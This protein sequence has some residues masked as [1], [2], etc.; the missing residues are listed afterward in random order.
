MNESIVSDSHIVLW[1]VP[2]LRSRTRFRQL[3]TR[4]FYLYKV[5]TRAFRLYH[6]KQTNQ[7]TI[8]RSRDFKYVTINV[9]K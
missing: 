2:N 4:F 5:D 9:I 8:F 3:M 1:G 7:E 6:G